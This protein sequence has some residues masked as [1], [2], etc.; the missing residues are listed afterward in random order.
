VFI[1]LSILTTMHVIDSFLNKKTMYQLVLQGLSV[2]VFISIVFAFFGLLPFTALDLLVSLVILVFSAFVSNALFALIFKANPTKESTFITALILFFIFAPLQDA[3]DGALLMLAAFV[4]IASKYLLAW[5]KK[6]LFNP[7][8]VAAFVFSV[9]GL[10]IDTWWVAT[11]IL[12]PFVLVVGL[13]FV[14]K[15]RRFDLFVSFI[16]ISTIVFSIRSMLLGTAPIAALLVFFGSFPVIF[17]G[18]VMLTEPQTSPHTKNDRG[19]YGGIVGVFFSL[20]FNFGPLAST[21]EFALL[22][23]NI[24]A[25]AVSSLRRRITLTLHS[26]KQVSREVYEF[27]FEPSQ[28]FAFQAG[29][30]MEW[31]APHAHPDSRGI[32]RFF[33]IASAPSD[34][35]VRLGVRLPVESSTFKDVLKNIRKNATLSAT[36]VAGDFILPKDPAQKIAA[37][38]G[39]IGI[40][41][42]M[43]MFRQLAQD[44]Q[45]R[46][47]TLIYVAASP[48]D[49]AYQEELNEIQ[50]KIGLT[51]LYLPTGF[52]ELNNWKGPSGYLTDVLIQE[53]IPDFKERCWYLSG[54]NAMVEDYSWIIRKMGVQ[55]RA[56]HKDY[57]P[58]F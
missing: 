26:S 6:H 14:R 37:I 53:K 2:L 50:A 22:V 54:P 30:Y 48:L 17:F 31:T 39:G 24:Y 51:I 34:V 56:I 46:N 29:Q 15:V 20:S 9:A 23:G 1:N 58:G 27:L 55:S 28:P 21:P 11:P 12:L 16:L 32:R 4:A 47:I 42:F 7:A 19:I 5:N 45:R 52:T 18:T 44:G 25:F 35:F 3:H 57:F 13:L 33:T 43:S 10:G 8:A 38:A 36:G 40:T 49:F 41:P